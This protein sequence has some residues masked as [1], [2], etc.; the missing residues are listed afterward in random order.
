MIRDI[1]GWIRANPG[2]VA[3][4]AAAAAALGMTVEQ[5]LL[6]Y[7]VPGKHRK[8]NVLN[9]KA[10]HRSLRRAEGFEKF[11][12]KVLNFT[13]HTNLKQISR[14]RKSRGHKANCGCVSCRAA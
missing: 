13:C 6:T 12:K 7:G 5:Y 9:P 11:A 2:K 8:M 4:V 3:G 14:K 1:G 10:L